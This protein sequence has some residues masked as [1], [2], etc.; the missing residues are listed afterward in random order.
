[1]IAHESWH[2][3]SWFA[4]KDRLPSW[5]EE[6]IATQN[7]AIVWD[8]VNPSFDPM[9]NFRRWT[10]LQA[11]VREHRLW[12]VRDMTATHAGKVVNLAQ[13]HID[14]YYAQLWAMVVFLEQSE[15]Y[16]PKLIALLKGAREGKLSPTLLGS[17][18][19]PYDIEHLQSSGTRSRDRDIWRASSTQT[20]L[21][22]RKSMMRL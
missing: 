5:L 6:G 2:Q 18:A 19:T 14:A 8:G 10:S 16:R 15:E 4:F 12:A 9:K 17:A 22:S 1:M 11:A 21:A 13:K 20:S 7:E 3:Y